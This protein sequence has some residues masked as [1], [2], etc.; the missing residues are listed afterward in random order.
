[1]SNID[2]KI[3]KICK[4]L[5]KNFDAEVIC[6]KVD[7]GQ[8]RITI[9]IS[10]KKVDPKNKDASPYNLPIGL[11]QIDGKNAKFISIEKTQFF[12]KTLFKIVLLIISILGIKSLLKSKKKWDSE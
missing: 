5:E 2:K 1:M 3:K 6:G 8:E 4:R 7:N 12:L 11:I 9:P 10:I